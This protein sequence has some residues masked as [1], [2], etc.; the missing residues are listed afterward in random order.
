MDGSG[1][2]GPRAIYNVDIFN[3]CWLWRDA[4]L[5]DIAAVRVRAGRI[6]YYFQLSGD[7]VHRKFRPARTAHG[8]LEIRAG[9]DGDVLASVPLPATPAKDGFIDLE[10]TLPRQAG[11]R[12]LCFTFSGDTRPAMWAIDSVRLVPRPD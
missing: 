5:A 4:P 9:C 6:P 2:D 7:E 12:D 3:P 10:A 11:H 8:E 1:P